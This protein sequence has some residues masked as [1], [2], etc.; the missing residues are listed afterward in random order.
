MRA[1]L[2]V[3]SVYAVNA[4]LRVKYLSRETVHFLPGIVAAKSKESQ[5]SVIDAQHGKKDNSAVT[6][7]LTVYFVQGAI[8]LSSLAVSYYLK[9]DLKMSPAESGALMGVASLPWVIKP[10]YGLITDGFPFAGYRRRSYL[11]LSSTLGSVA[12]ILMGTVVHD[13]IGALLCIFVSSMSIAASDV[14]AD[15]LAVE[16]SRTPRAPSKSI[17]SGEDEHKQNQRE[18]EEPQEGTDETSTAGDLQS[19]CKGM[20]ATGGIIAAYFSGSLLETLHPKSVFLLTAVLPVLTGT[21]AALLQEPRQPP[22][23]TSTTSVT[24]Q[25]LQQLR[26]LRD[27]LK[28]PAIYLPVAFIFLWQAT[29]SA[30]ATMFYYYTSALG[31]SPEFLG[32]VRLASS[33]AALLGVLAYRWKLKDVPLRDVLRWS[34]VL[35]VPLSLSQVLLT[36]HWNRALGIPDQAFTLSDSVVLTALG[37]ISFLPV[38]VLASS[39]CPPGAEGALFA[40]LM[41]VFNGAGILGNELGAALTGLLGITGTNFDHLSGLIVLCSFANL[42]PLLFIDKLLLLPG[43]KT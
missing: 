26:Q 36:T 23:P 14:I 24:S 42:I 6:S 7:I 41:S 16:Q 18:K 15:S 20:Y 11:F 21:A 29:P 12:W 17:P 33:V 19:L 8:S 4:F 30:G 39:L 32:E 27:T 38:L 10:I 22:Q 37:E 34:I 13:A 43:K 31:F 9:D 35:S 3:L 40:T 1:P 2:L 28:N 5:C 25:I